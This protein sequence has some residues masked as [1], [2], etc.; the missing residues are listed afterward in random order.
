M[1]RRAAAQNYD[2]MVRSR[3]VDDVDLHWET[4]TI[5]YGDGGAMEGE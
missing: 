3:G 1:A 5:V 4:D 2:W